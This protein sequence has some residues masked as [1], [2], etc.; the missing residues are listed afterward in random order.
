MWQEEEI[1]KRFELLEERNETN[2]SNNNSFIVENNLISIE[3]NII[4]NIIVQQ[5]ERR[6]EQ[7]RA[8]QS[9]PQHRETG[10]EREGRETD[11]TDRQT[12]DRWQID[13]SFII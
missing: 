11:W 2:L 6:P 9:T 13:I 10:K 5:Q 12:D 7:S 1:K 3:E 8:G 4:I